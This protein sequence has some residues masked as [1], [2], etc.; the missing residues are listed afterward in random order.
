MVTIPTT[1]ELYQRI[2]TNIEAEL[3]IS[4]PPIGKF[5]VRIFAL[6]MAGALKL[7]YLSIGFVQRNVFVDTADSESLGGTLERFGRVYLGRNPDPARAGEYD[8]QVTG[9]I[10]AVIPQSTTFKSDDS[11]TSPGYLFILD[12]AYTLT[13]AT[14]TINV[15]ALTPGLEAKLLVAD[16]L[17]ATQPITN[18]DQSAVVTA[19]TV[20]PIAAETLEDYRQKAILQVRLEPQ[21]GAG[22][23]YRLWSLD[24]AGVKTSYPFRNSGGTAEVNVFVEAT[25]ADS[26]DSKGTPTPSILAEVEDVIEFDPDPTQPPEERARR[27]LTAE[28]VNVLPVDVQDVDIDIAGFVDLTPEKDTAI[29]NSIGL[30]IDS[31]RPF[32]ST[33]DIPADQNDRLDVNSIIAAIFEAVPGAQFTT[34]TMTVGGS[35]VSSYTFIEDEI[36]F[37]NSVNFV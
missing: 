18:V 32:V 7:I 34:V 12:T 35:A 20:E 4:V 17:T 27:P 25:I 2:K 13:A 14:D 19:E 23:D 10:G 21:G 3:N 11:S 36:P 31:V 15:R 30:L 9:Q 24:A 8:L 6:V 29:T 1:P 37:S 26:A 16:T 5:F 33:A 22:T 28:T